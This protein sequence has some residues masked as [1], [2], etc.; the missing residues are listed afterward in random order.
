MG[1]TFRPSERREPGIS[2]PYFDYDP[3][4]LKLDPLLDSPIVTN[5]GLEPG[6]AAGRNKQA[7]DLRM[8]RLRALDRE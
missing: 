5:F 3:S 1:M 8:I 2:Q 4:L 7:K 6:C